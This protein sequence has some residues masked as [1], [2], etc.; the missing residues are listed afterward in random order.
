MPRRVSFTIK[1]TTDLDNVPGWGYHVSDWIKLATADFERQKHYNTTF[2]VIDVR[3]SR[4]GV[5][6]GEP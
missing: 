4:H 6:G 1:F 2:E 3:P 5:R